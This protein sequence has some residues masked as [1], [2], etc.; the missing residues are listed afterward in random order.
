M[1]PGLTGKLICDTC[2]WVVLKRVC[3]FA[4]V[5]DSFGP[6]FRVNNPSD[7]VPKLRDVPAFEKMER[8]ILCVVIPMIQNLY[9]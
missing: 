5:K 9:I 4:S 3:F 6:L 1:F 2:I 8:F 7:A